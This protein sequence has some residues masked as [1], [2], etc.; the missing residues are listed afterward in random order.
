MRPC[1]AVLRAA[2]LASLAT[3]G[4]FV[5][6]AGQTG[7][8]PERPIRVVLPFPPGGPS[9]IVMRQAAE[10]M[11]AALKQPIVVDNKPGAGGN[12]GSAEVARA[13]PDGYTWL[14]GP[15]SLITVNPHVYKHM[16]FKVDDLVPVTIATQFNQ[17]LVCNPAVGVKT[18]AELI[19]KAKA[20]PMSYASGEPAC[21]GIFR[22]SCCSRWRAS[23]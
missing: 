14:F 12:L 17:T 10:K 22:W 6:A 16:P 1:L 23:R 19:A 7:T 8:W 21:R 9:D 2:A 4:A 3:L 20:M 11:Q 18:V 15:D 5:P 13:A